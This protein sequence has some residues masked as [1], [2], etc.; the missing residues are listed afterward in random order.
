MNADFEKYL[1]DE[2]EDKELHLPTGKTE[3]MHDIALE[4]IFDA[5]VNFMLKTMQKKPTDIG[6]FDMK[7]FDIGKNLATLYYKSNK[8]RHKL[9]L[10]ELL[11]Y[12]Q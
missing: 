4:Y 12:M 2:I 3:S 1:N 10:F 7:F 11:S 5:G 9:R 6:S 8:R